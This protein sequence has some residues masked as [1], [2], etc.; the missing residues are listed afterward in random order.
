VLDGTLRAAPCTTLSGTAAGHSE[1]QYNFFYQM[2]KNF[3]LPARCVW[4]A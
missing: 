4:H 1:K 2:V 3:F